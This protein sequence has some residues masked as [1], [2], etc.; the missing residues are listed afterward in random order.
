MTSGCAND[1]A[2][3]QGTSR[4]GGRCTIQGAAEGLLP[5]VTV[6]STDEADAAQTDTLPSD[7]GLDTTPSDAGGPDASAT[8]DAS[9]EDSTDRQPGDATGGDDSGDGAA[10][11]WLVEPPK[12]GTMETKHAMAVAGDDGA[13]RGIGTHEFED[14]E[15]FA[16]RGMTPG[17]A[18]GDLGPQ[19]AVA[20][21]GQRHAH[22]E[23][24]VDR[25]ARVAPGDTGPPRLCAAPDAAPT[26]P[27]FA[28]SP[29]T[30]ARREA[31][32]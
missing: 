18:L 21:R 6:G 22:D 17:R 26:T 10:V 19:D 5:E 32:G 24:R 2:C 7:T 23:P 30:R 20:S 29:S 11:G 4:E 15:G 14:E 27:G 28:R 25:H 8:G 13:T 3:P 31:I 16:P 1:P 12:P 9:Q